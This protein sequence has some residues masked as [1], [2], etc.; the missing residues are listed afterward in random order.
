MVNT[1][2]AFGALQGVEVP[3][4]AIKMESE[5]ATSETSAVLLTC[6]KSAKTEEQKSTSTLFNV[7]GI[8]SD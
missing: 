4:S 2:S 8:I 3:K 7:N 6:T 5:Y 1:D